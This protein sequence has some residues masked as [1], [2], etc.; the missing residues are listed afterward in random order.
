MGG[1]NFKLAQ[2]REPIKIKIDV[3]TIRPLWNSRG[4]DFDVPVDLDEIEPLETHGLF[5]ES[6]PGNP[7]HPGDSPRQ[8]G[9]PNRSLRGLAA[10][11]IRI[12]AK[13]RFGPGQSA[14]S[15]ARREIDLFEDKF[16]QKV[17][18]IDRAVLLPKASPV[19]PA[20]I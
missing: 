20:M 11:P 18:E 19:L 10:P 7:I 13:L 15:L 4:S 2:Y 14:A 1:F 3:V 5:G 8:E 6:L 17:F 12:S 16:D 9:G